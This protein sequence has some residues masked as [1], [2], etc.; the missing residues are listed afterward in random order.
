MRAVLDRL[1]TISGALSALL[2]LA[3]CGVIGLQILFNIITRLRIIETSLTIP[4]Y[5]DISGYLLAAASFLALA[6][7]LQRGGH[8]RVTLVLTMA[9]PGFRYVADAVS[10]AVCGVISALATYYVALMTYQSYVFNDLSPGILAIPVWIAQVP[11]TLGLAILTVAFADLLIQTLRN[12]RPLPE[13]RTL[14]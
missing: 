7:A 6:Y 8:I 11:V 1:Y 10:L 9:G 12:G 3:I 5:A 4:S 13:T 14:E 2:I